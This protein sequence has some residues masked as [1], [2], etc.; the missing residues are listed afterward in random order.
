MIGAIEAGGTKFVC[1]V[2]EDGEKIL[3]KVMIATTTPAETL[4]KVVAFFD[5]FSIHAIGI[6]SF[7]PIDVNKDS[8][9]YGYITSTPKVG[10][11]YFNFIGSIREKYKVHVAWT[12][13]VNASAYGEYHKG[14]ARDVSSCLYLTVGTGIGGGAII[15]GNIL[16]GFSHPE[17]GHILVRKNK[18]DLFKGI[19]PYHE[20]CLEGL[21]SRPAIEARYGV[22]ATT[23]YNRKDVWELIA[24]YLAQ[25][26][27]TY[28]LALRV[29]KVIIGGGV[30]NHT[31][32]Y[33]MIRQK[34]K[35]LMND[36]IS[37]P[38]LEEYIVAP[39]LNDEQALIGCFLL[40]Q[41]LLNKN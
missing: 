29:E 25:A 37:T 15:N 40:A 8:P 16:E 10:W 26:I 31:N 33:I 30:M 6:G 13:D 39:A 14:A 4:Q 19:C 24:D 22:T 1:A 12:T 21:A 32:L 3:D 18:Q 7:G 36:Y 17:M 35:Q 38:N 20:D 2:T 11:D 27:F 23:L 28:T 5:C 34:F 41:D 9:H